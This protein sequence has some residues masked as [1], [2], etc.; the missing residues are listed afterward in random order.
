L[1]DE[2]IRLA[3]GAVNS[4]S[5]QPSINADSWGIGH[6]ERHQ[7]QEA[8]TMQSPPT[9]VA[10]SP[11]EHPLTAYHIETPADEAT[12]HYMYQ[13]M[14]HENQFSN[15]FPPRYVLLLSDQIDP[16]KRVPYDVFVQLDANARLQYDVYRL[17]QEDADKP[18]TEQEII[19]SLRSTPCF[20]PD[21]F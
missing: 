3:V 1:L 12:L 20:F 9:V 7:V 6:Q 17:A 11:I 2:I 18:Y 16:A 15:D 14:M 10:Y 8:L 5:G 19:Q 21:A 4:S 13:S